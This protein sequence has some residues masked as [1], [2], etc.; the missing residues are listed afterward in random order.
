MSVELPENPNN[1]EEQYLA[2]AVGQGVEVPECPWSRKEAYLDAIGDRINSLDQEIKDLEN[3]PDVVDIVD[4]YADLVAYDTSKLTDKDIIRV[5]N[6]ETHDGKSTYYRYG[7]T[8]DSWTYIGSSSSSE[9]PIKTISVNGTNVPPDSDKNVALTIPD[10]AF[11]GTDGTS[12]GTAGLVP[13]PATTDAGKYLKA[14]GS[15]G[16]V[17]NVNDYVIKNAGAPTTST[18]GTVGK[19]YEDI[20]NGKLYQLT[21]IDT[22]DPQNPSY[23]WTEVGGGSSVNIVQTVGS[24]QTD[25]MSQDAV[26]T[27]LGLKEEKGT[28][29]AV[30]I[31]S[32]DWSA[33]SAS[34][35]YTYSAT[36]TLT[37]TIG[38]NST[39][40][41]IN[42][43]A[44]D[45][46]TYGFA[47]GSVDQPNNTITVYS[48]GQ[49]DASK[50]L[51]VNVKG[52]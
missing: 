11:T 47:I 40:S 9:A 25:V 21:A 2:K 28:D 38:A 49:P 17:E 31:A 29:E 52:A 10:S 30:S 13:A 22:T 23:T 5:L 51:T 3:N 41:L 46:A 26:T 19:L 8:N 1:R 39:V 18:E 33:L 7:K 24:S 6:D 35:P 43:A 16:A 14:N 45:Y 27:N 32:A 44:V 50:T 20:T 34:T 12:A 4:T 15:W 48:I 37:A 36:K 42:D